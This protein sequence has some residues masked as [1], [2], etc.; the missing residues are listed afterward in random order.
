[1]SQKYQ[2]VKTNFTLIRKKSIFVNIRKLKFWVRTVMEK[3]NIKNK[4]I[5]TKAM[6]VNLYRQK[7]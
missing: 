4:Y 1:M 3:F 2:P 5:Y 6:D 7:H